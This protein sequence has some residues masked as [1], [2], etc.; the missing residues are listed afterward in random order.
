[1]GKSSL[2][3]AVLEQKL[4]TM[5]SVIEEGDMLSLE[6]NI[7]GDIRDRRSLP[8]AEPHLHVN[9]GNHFVPGAHP[10]LSFSHSTTAE[11][12]GGLET[13]FKLLS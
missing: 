11:G 8:K 5:S 9:V 6:T 4:C 10:K 13:F 1:M 12:F 2:C 7:Q 3:L